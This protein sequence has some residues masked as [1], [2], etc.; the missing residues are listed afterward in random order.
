M[1]VA[2]PTSMDVAGGI[3]QH[4]Y[5]V[6]SNVFENLLYWDDRTVDVHP[7]LAERY[8]VSEDGLAYTFHLR[9]GVRFH[10]GTEMD[11]EAVRFSYSRVLDP[12]DEFYKAGQ[13]FPLMDFWY[14]AI[15]PK[16]TVVHDKYTVTLRLK[17][18]YSALE[19]T[20]AWPAAGIV[21]PAAVKKY[22]GAFREH[23]VGTG[24]FKFDSWVHNEKVTFSRFDGYWGTKLFG[25]LPYLD[26]LVFRPL[27]E[28]QTRVTELLA[29]N[30]DFA[31]DLPPDN[32]AQ[33]KASPRVRFLE[34]PLGHVWFL[35][36]NTK[37][38]PTKDARVRRAIASAIDK[39][40]IIKDILK[41]T[42]VP[43]TG[44]VPSVITYAHKDEPVSYDPDRA[45]GLL[46]EAGYAGGFRTKFWVPESGS[47]MQSP[48]AMAEA[49]QAMLRQAGIQLDL[50]V[51]E[52]GAYLNVYA[53][54]M[55]DDVGV[56]EMSWFTQDAQNIPHLTVTC[57]TVSP[58]GY[59]AGYYCNQEVDAL[60]KQFWATI[61]KKKQAQFMFKVQDILAS[62]M[63]NVY[64]DT[65]VDTAGLSTKFTGFS[66]HPSQLLR[67]WKTQLA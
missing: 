64:I 52:W 53:K 21:S 1:V 59:N 28:E 38:G 30:I 13:P 7:G 2:E 37:A 26:T 35:V 32:V 49:I 54:G 60:L 61:D 46:K 62:D 66:L 10:D 34:T 43:A 18:P 63:P 50:Q 29:G 41:G 17:Y 48:K 57:S 8:E 20:F 40:A 31:Y 33:V 39:Q 55:P 19:W 25:G 22:R 3:G 67:F 4:N 24:P 51:Y 45:K 27:V 6:M 23:P 58:K 15:D 9:R 56:A 14:G 12:D 36:L 42:A 11:A 65:Q 44:P 16:K 5:A 47:G